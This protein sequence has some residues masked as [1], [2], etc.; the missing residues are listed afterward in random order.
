[1]G[2]SPHH[3]VHAG[4]LSLRLHTFTS[5]IVDT[6]VSIWRHG[7]RKI[8][9]VNGHGGNIAPL[10]A[11]ANELTT[12]GYSVPTVSY[13]DLVKED[14]RDLLEGE[15]KTVG[16]ACEFETSLMLFQRPNG[17]DMTTA[18]RDNHPPWNPGADTDIFTEHGVTY[19]AVFR[20]GSS[21]VLGDPTL[22]SAD[23]GRRLFELASERLATFIIRY[24]TNDLDK[25]G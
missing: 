9:I 25:R 4:T 14:L 16:H 11:I 1:M 15:R 5:V 3:M 22:A 7:F 24:R 23:K 17:V 18:V 19:P 10:A 6:V 12:D 21:G 13:W 2:F 20:A 8:L